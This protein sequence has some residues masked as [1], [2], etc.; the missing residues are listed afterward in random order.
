M[1]VGGGGDGGDGDGSGGELE[2]VERWGEDGGVKN[3]SSEE[4]EEEEE[5]GEEGGDGAGHTGQRQ[6][7]GADLVERPEHL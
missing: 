6:A 4:E 1:S 5:E 3:S 2:A 7:G